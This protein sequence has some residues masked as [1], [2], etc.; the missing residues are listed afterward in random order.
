L[1]VVVGSMHQVCYFCSFHVVLLIK[2]THAE[3]VYFLFGEKA[4][5]SFPKVFFR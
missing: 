1:P 3:H 4:P 2:C 5:V